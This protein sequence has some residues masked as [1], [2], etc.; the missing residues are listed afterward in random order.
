MIRRLALAAV[1]ATAVVASAVVAVAVPLSASRA[2]ARLHLRLKAAFPAKDTTLTSAP[3]AVRLWLSE[4]ADLA[5]TKIEVRNVSGAVVPTAALTRGEPRDAPVVALF[6]TPPGNGRY[7]I[8]WRAMSK[9]GHVV[10]GT[11]AF[12]VRVAE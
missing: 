10:K 2:D 9:D 12:T 11:H 6:T 1:V 5:A 7:V 3:D 4:P 8:D